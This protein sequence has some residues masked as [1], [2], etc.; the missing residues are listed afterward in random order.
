MFNSTESGTPVHSLQL[1]IPHT[2]CT[3]GPMF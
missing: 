1:V 2:Y 3:G